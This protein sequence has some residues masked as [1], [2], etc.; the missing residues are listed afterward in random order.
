M[1][2]GKTQMCN[3]TN[4]LVL[5]VENSCPQVWLTSRR[6]MKQNK[7]HRPG[8]VECWLCCKQI[9][10][11]LGSNPNNWL[12][13]RR[14]TQGEKRKHTSRSKKE[15]GGTVTVRGGELLC[16]QTEENS[17]RTVNCWRRQCGLSVEIHHFCGE[18]HHVVIQPQSRHT[19]RPD[20]AVVVRPTVKPV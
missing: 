12:D 1:C 11:D 2:N 20:I 18:K 4:R 14:E 5:A 7:R 17:N 10:R 19:N 6:K 3:G 16:I 13:L 9:K 8:Q 15:E